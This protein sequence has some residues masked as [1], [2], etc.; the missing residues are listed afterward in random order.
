[1]AVDHTAT[2]YSDSDT[3]G[4]HAAR[5]HRYSACKREAAKLVKVAHVLDH[6]VG[7]QEET[8]LDTVF[9]FVGVRQD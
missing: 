8:G 9:V 4:S 3:G 6:L 5:A 1:M 7:E 2:Y